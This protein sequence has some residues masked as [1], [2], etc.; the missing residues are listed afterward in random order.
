MLLTLSCTEPNVFQVVTSRDKVNHE[1]VLGIGVLVS[2][3]WGNAKTVLPNF[4]G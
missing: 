2:M 3:L 4:F 1:K